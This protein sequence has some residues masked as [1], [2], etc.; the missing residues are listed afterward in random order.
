MVMGICMLMTKSRESKNTLDTA[1][2]IRMFLSSFTVGITNP[3]AIFSFLFAFLWFGIDGQIRL[4]DGIGLV[5]GVFIGTYIWW[6]NLSCAVV[7]LKKNSK[8]NW[9]PIMN[10]V[11]GIVISIRTFL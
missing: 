9:F 2:G 4:L 11:F 5:A 3:A 6:G 10:R 8:N 7:L 1:K